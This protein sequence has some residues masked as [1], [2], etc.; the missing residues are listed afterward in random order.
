MRPWAIVQYDNRPLDTDTKA[1]VA[2]NKSYCDKHGYTHIFET[3][4]YD[5]PPYWIKVKLVQETLMSRR[6]SGVL[7]LDSDAVV[8]DQEKR[9]DELVVPNKSFYYCADA[10]VWDSAFNAGVW[11]VLN[12]AMGNTIME[13]WMGAYDPTTWNEKGGKWTSTGVWAGPT[14]EQGAFLEYIM[15]RYDQYMH[16]YPWSFFQSYEAVP[17]NFAMHFAGEFSNTHLPG[18]LRPYDLLLKIVYALVTI[19]V[20]VALVYPALYSEILKAISGVTTMVTT[21]LKDHLSSYIE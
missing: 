10:P 9:L 19:V 5:L 2:R 11:L 18:Y 7:W 8:H 17:T 12:D 15:P 3:K 13:S 16:K 14:Y 6:F 4:K 20:L 21:S 1:L